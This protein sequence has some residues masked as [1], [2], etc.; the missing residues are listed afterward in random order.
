MKNKHSL[1]KTLFLL[2]F[3]YACPIGKQCRATQVLSDSCHY[4]P[5]VPPYVISCVNLHAIDHHFVLNSRNVAPVWI[6]Q[7]V[8][9]SFDFEGILTAVPVSMVII[10]QW[11]ATK[12]CT[13][14]CMNTVWPH[15][16][17]A[18]FRLSFLERHWFSGAENLHTISMW[19][20]KTSLC[21]VLFLSCKLEDMMV[22]PWPCLRQTPSVHRMGAQ[23]GENVCVH[24]TVKTHADGTSRA[25]LDIFLFLLSFMHHLHYQGCTFEQDKC[26]A[27]VICHTLYLITHT[28]WID[29]FLFI[30][31]SPRGIFGTS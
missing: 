2:S 4:L 26:C 24:H 15:W 23:M 7:G 5:P 9:D 29:W 21:L 27:R 17:F 10:F 13:S 16:E 18:L 20:H 31:W 1:W 3:C 14:S 19:N 22:I 30:Y 25:S 8:K 6:Q 11:H 12:S 28:S